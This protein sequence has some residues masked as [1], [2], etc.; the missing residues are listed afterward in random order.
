MKL[1]V[2][3]LA[4]S[5]FRDFSKITVFEEQA[6]FIPSMAELLNRFIGRD[7]EAY[8]YLAGARC[9]GRA[10]GIIVVTPTYETADL[11]SDGSSLCWVDTLA[12][13]KQFQRRG[14]GKKLLEHSIAVIKSRHDVLCLTVDIRNISAKAMYLKSGF[15][16]S[17][18]LYLGGSAGPQHILQYELPKSA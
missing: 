13:D 15:Q 1:E 10:A 8:V 2:T 16:D 6:R 3:A 7:A 4:E 11:K 17:G 5:D 18:E 9:D 14:V 12:V